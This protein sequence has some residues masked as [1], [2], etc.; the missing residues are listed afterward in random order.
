M[1]TITLKTTL[2]SAAI[3]LLCATTAPVAAA[4]V[5][6]ELDF[7]A[8][9]DPSFGTAAGETLDYVDAAAGVNARLTVANSFDAANSANHGAAAGDARVNARIGQTAELS[10]SIFDASVGNGFEQEYSAAGGFTWSLVFYDV[11]GFDNSFDSVLLR[12]AGTVTLDSNSLLSV[13]DTAQGVL[14]EGNLNEFIGNGVPI[15][16]NVLTQDGVASLNADQQAA[17]FAYTVTNEATIDFDYI[18]G[19]VAG[20]QTNGRNLL[21]DGGSLLSSFDNP[22]EVEVDVAP[23]PLPAGAVLLLTGLGGVAA[24]KRRKTKAA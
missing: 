17:A 21:I 11:D 9:S 8:F 14:V 19:A 7:G 18:V 10:L 12:T 1:K 15:N 23:V 20:N 24:L 16:G 5:N 2:A 22:V 13:S 3:G 6:L 4:T